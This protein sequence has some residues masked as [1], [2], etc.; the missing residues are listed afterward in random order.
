MAT[1]RPAAVVRLDPDGRRANLAE[2]GPVH[3]RVVQLADLQQGVA[4][5][6]AGVEAR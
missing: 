1:D 3:P 6:R 4:G 2:Q 5:L